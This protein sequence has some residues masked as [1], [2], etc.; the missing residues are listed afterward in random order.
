MSTGEI[1]I[2]IG[3]ALA[4]GLVSNR[5]I[6]LVHLPNV[7]G[8]LI[9]GILMGPY[10]VGLINP[11]LGGILNKELVHGLGVLVDLALGFIAF[12][13]TARICCPRRY[14]RQWEQC[15]YSEQRLC[16]EFCF[17]KKDN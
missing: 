8:Y 4:A 5:L 15:L 7:T 13:I 16:A 9:V 10:L 12:S 2:G 6:R 3:L 14:L 17:P 1:L 11:S